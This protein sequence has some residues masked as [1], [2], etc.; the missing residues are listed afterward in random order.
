M[1]FMLGGVPKPEY[2]QF[3]GIKN[4]VRMYSYEINQTDTW[5]FYERCGS[6]LGSTLYDIRS[7]KVYG[8]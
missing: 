7:E 2:S 6:S 3:S 8:D 4:L 1:F 5:I